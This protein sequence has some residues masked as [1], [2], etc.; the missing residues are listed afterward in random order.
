MEKGIPLGHRDRLVPVANRGVR[1]RIYRTGSIRFSGPRARH[2]GLPILLRLLISRLTRGRGR[3]PQRRI[4]RTGASS[5]PLV[6]LVSPR[7]PFH[8]TGA[9]R[10]RWAD[11]R[12]LAP[13]QS[14]RYQTAAPEMLTHLAGFEPGT[15]KIGFPRVESYITRGGQLIRL[16]SLTGRSAVIPMSISLVAWSGW[17]VSASGNGISTVA[18]VLA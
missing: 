14:V 7:A 11:Q 15:R 4:G 2:M 6:R 13:R 18:P 1:V 16:G 10:P 3:P 12:D 17:I 8:M 9:S 5:L